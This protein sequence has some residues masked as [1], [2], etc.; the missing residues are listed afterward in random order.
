M[1]FTWQQS[2]YKKPE[3]W[4]PE[5]PA[6]RKMFRSPDTYGF[7]TAVYSPLKNLD[8]SLSAVYTGKMLL[9]HFAGYAPTD[10]EETSPEF[11]DMG[12]KVAYDIK[13]KENIILQINV[14]IKN[15]LNSY[16]HDFDQ[17]EFRDAG[18][19]YGPTLPRS[20]YIGVKFSI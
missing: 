6:Q 4:S 15:I 16:Q 2:L 9:Q 19:I 13:M 20:V 5:V 8:L 10:R 7:V 3:I 14:G 18:Y 1:G 11:F 12:L 17:G